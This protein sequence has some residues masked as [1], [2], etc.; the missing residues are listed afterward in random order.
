VPPASARS[1]SVEATVARALSLAPDRLAVFG[2]AHVPWMKRHQ[3][4]MPLDTLPDG[5]ER[6]AQRATIERLATEAGYVALGLDHFARPGDGLAR[7]AAEGRM[8][9][10][11]QGYTADEAE[12]LIGLGASAIGSMPQGYVQNASELPDYRAAVSRGRLPVVRG[13][14]LDAED[15][16]RRQM[17]ETIMCSLALDLGDRPGYAAE[18]EALEALRRDGLIDWD[19]A[20]LRVTSAGRPY[21]RAVAAVFDANLGTGPGRHSRAV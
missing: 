9:R 7:A 11:F 21:L 1:T 19:G 12:V 13:Y 4:L 16:A 8:R 6:F 18:R 15:R 2:Y 3:T 14:A 17:I 20:S 10:N 5:A